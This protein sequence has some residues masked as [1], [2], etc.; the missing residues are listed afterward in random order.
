MIN[1]WCITLTRPVPK[2]P[3]SK[4]VRIMYNPGRS[5]AH[6]NFAQSSCGFFLF[7]W[8]VRGG[9]RLS[10][11]VTINKRTYSTKRDHESLGD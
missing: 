9:M 1:A 2:P 4:D 6:N 11:K 7:A 8:Y 5:G 3:L 10:G